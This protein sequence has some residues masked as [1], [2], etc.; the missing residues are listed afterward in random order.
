MSFRLVV[1]LKGKLGFNRLLSWAVWVVGGGTLVGAVFVASFFLAMRA[2]MRSSQVDVP[3]LS[4]LT[5]ESARQKAE[6]DNLIL[7]VVEQRN[8]PRVPSGRVIEQVPRPGANVRRGRKMKL[9]LSLGG[10]VLEV[11]DLIGHAARAVAIELRQE[12]FTPGGE[13][14]VHSHDLEVGKVIA[15]VPA[16]GTRVVPNSRVHRLVSDGPPPA[17]WIMPDLTGR[18]RDDAERWIRLC[19]FRRGAIRR[20]EGPDRTAGTV[21]AQLP[22]AGY[23]IRSKDIVELAVA[24]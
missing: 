6:S 24:E 13:A 11:P 9:I 18:T 10:R 17:T 16:A 4:G 20:V 3:D 15:Q 21:V 14:R 23:P 5:L 22:L 19:G 8:D 1:Q 7:E 12:T 2:E